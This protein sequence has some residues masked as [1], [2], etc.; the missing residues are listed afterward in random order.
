M[1][2]TIKTDQEIE[3]MRHGGAVLGATLQYAKKVVAPGMSTLELSDLIAKELRANGVDAAFVGYQGYPAAACISVNEQV[4]HGMP[5]KKRILKAG[6]L[7]SIDVGVSYKGMITDAALSVYLSPEEVPP[8]A[9]IEELMQATEQALYAG[10]DVAHGG[11]RVGTVSAAVQSVLNKGQFGIV[12]DLVGHGVG[13][14][15]HEDPN[16]P[17]Y[18]IK[19]SGPTLVAGMT[20]AVEPMAT[21]GDWRI[22]ILDDGWTVVTKDSSL[23]CHFEHTILIT[24]GEPEILTLAPSA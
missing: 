10:I 13:Y 9:R 3:A 23:A 4:V 16:I 22:A 7:V 1:V 2:G 19:G 8:T 5:S 20:V 18:G 11:T 6:D 14:D 17:N 15:I 21:L 12:R 24:E